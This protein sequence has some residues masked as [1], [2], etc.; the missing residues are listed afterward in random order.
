MGRRVGDAVGGQQGGRDAC[1][2]GHRGGRFPVRLHRCA[3]MRSNKLL[4]RA[5]DLVCCAPSCVAGAVEGV[6]VGTHVLGARCLP[7]LDAHACW[8]RAAD[9]KLHEWHRWQ[10]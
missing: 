5:A 6:L 4:T 8:T 1:G 7:G 3:G 9:V 2:A 10:E